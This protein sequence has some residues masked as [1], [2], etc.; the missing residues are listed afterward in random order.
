MHTFSSRRRH[1]VGS[2][3]LTT[4][5]AVAAASCGIIT[6]GVS[7]PEAFTHNGDLGLKGQLV[8]D[9]GAP[10]DEVIVEVTRDYYLWHADASYTETTHLTFAADHDFSIEPMRAQELAF[11]FKKVG[12]LDAEISVDKD[13]IK[14]PCGCEDRMCPKSLT[15]LAIA[16]YIEQLRGSHE[17]IQQPICAHSEVHKARGAAWREE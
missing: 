7:V 4:A 2:L 8:D 16:A 3:I 12:Y 14:Q 11:T 1:L 15:P 13:G 6:A 5:A 9:H 10:V 17:G